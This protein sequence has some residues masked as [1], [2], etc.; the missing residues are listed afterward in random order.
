MATCNIH[1]AA[2]LLKIH[3]QTLLELIDK[4]ILPAAKIGRA[5][6]LLEDDVIMYLTKEVTKQTAL[7]LGSG[8]QPRPKSVRRRSSPKLIGKI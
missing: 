7:R 3:W 2:E 4:G 8:R 5:W 6:V 1:Q